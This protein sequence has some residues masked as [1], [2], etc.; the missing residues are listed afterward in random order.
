MDH[1]PLILAE[2]ARQQ[3][4]AGNWE[5]AERNYLTAI[6]G[7]KGARPAWAPGGVV[8]A[9]RTPLQR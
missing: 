9:S 6:E 4:V 1:Q 7:L 5:N 2:K 3:H 8:L